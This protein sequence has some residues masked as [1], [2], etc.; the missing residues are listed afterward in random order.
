[1]LYETELPIREDLLSAHGA[2]VDRWSRPGTWWTGA[3][4]LAIVT[5]VRRARDCETAPPPWVPVSTVEGLVSEDHVLPASG[6]GNVGRRAVGL[7]RG[8]R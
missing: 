8:S 4:R 1:M 7:G 5:E 6:R 3:E 2:V